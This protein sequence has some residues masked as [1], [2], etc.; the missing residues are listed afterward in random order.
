MESDTSQGSPGTSPGG[1]SCG[2]IQLEG[3]KLNFWMLN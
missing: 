1:K 3:E 2:P